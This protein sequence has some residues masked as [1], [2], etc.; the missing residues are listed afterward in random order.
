VICLS[1]FI[2]IKI[3]SPILLLYI[4]DIA[5]KA[6][7]LDLLRHITTRLSSKFAMANL[8]AL[9]H[10]LG[11][12]ITRSSNRLFLLQ[13]QYTIELFQCASI[14]ECHPTMMPMDSKSKLS[15]TDGT[16]VTNPSEYRR[17]VR[18]LQYLTLTHLD[19]AYTVQQVCL[20]MP[21][22]RELHLALVKHILRYIKGILSTGLHTSISLVQ[23]LMAYS[24]ADCVGCPDSRRSTLGYCIYLSDILVSWSS[25]R[26]TTVSRSSA[27]A[28]YHVIAHVIAESCAGCAG[29]S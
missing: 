3:A 16:L 17:L 24:N 2:K 1:L 21:D 22:P 12:S 23:S 14:S 5:P 27:E 19:L 25:K 15:A 7:T 10:F 11:I 8:G 20:F 29:F 6:S 18:A 4:N 13:C 9:H 28:E 26:Q